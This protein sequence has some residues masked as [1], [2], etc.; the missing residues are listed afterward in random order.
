[1]L[2]DG[3]DQDEAVAALRHDAVEDQRGAATLAA[4]EQRFGVRVA[5]IVAE[6]G[7][8]D[9]DRSVPPWRV[10]KQRQIDGL[11]GKSREALR[12]GDGAMRRLLP[13]LALAALLSAGGCGEAALPP[14]EPTDAPSAPTPTAADRTHASPTA[15][16]SPTIDTP[17]LLGLRGISTE[18][19]EF[20]YRF[21]PDGMYAYVGIL[22]Q[23]PPAPSS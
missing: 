2:E 15:D 9:P 17:A 5:G 20:L 11:A 7:D 3:G 22:S 6:C 23:Q 1:M 12:G 4:I 10:R 14:D 18:E 13:G 16:A 21:D 19:V 8:H